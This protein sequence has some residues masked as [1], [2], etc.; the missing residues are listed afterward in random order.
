MSYLHH[1]TP[2]LKVRQA[3]VSALALLSTIARA[4]LTPLFQLMDF[5]LSRLDDLTVN[6]EGPPPS[7]GGHISRQIK[8][9]VAAMHGNGRVFIDLQLLSADVLWKNPTLP[10]VIFR[11]L[12]RSGIRPIPVI[13][14]NTPPTVL[15][16]LK[17][18][19]KIIDCGFMIRL[20]PT[21]I[22]QLPTIQRW[23]Q[24][25][26]EKIDILLD[27][28]SILYDKLDNFVYSAASYINTSLPF[29]YQ[30]RS[31]TIASGAFPG[32]LRSYLPSTQNKIARLDSRF[33]SRLIQQGLERDPWYADYGIF[34]PGL[35]ASLGKNIAGICYTANHDWYILRSPDIVKRNSRDFCNQLINQPFYDNPGFSYADS[36]IFKCAMGKITITSG[37]EWRKIS[38]NRHLEKTCAMLTH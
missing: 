30:W 14:A 9:I 12:Y 35:G 1:Y 28:G 4:N 16:E 31:L 23:L 19:H 10:K 27:Y 11:E 18:F 21:S 6:Y 24:C 29:L 8:L 7:I 20:N 32:H 37:A 17:E 33:W 2:V 26:P 25:P 34:P 5:P 15:S 36:Q 22:A 3:E 13:H 38:I